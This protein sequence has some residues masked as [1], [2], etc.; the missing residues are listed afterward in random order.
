MHGPG[1]RGEL[2]VLVLIRITR[3]YQVRELSPEDRRLISEDVFS[4]H[5]GIVDALVDGDVDVART[6]LRRHLDR[7]GARLARNRRRLP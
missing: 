4:T 1:R 5:G 6:R 3:L 7:V 2:V